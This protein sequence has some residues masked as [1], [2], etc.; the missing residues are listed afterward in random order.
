VP[1]GR[2]APKRQRIAYPDL[3]YA[4]DH[5]RLEDITPDLAPKWLN[6]GAED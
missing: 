6:L 2:S 5:L 1:I 3:G 4:V